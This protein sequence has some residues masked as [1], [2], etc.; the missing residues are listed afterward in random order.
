[1]P[2]WIHNRAD[3]IRSKNPSMPKSEAFAIATQQS[4]ATGKA[5]KS[6]GTSEGHHEAKKKYDAPKSE[7]KKEADP[8]HKSKTS[9]LSMDFWKGF[10]D[11]LID[12]AKNEK[13]LLAL[14]ANIRDC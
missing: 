10:S 7:Y 12:L 9:S 8:S 1:M 5:P 2:A 4:Y 6:Y 14:T 13:N 11:E 3:H